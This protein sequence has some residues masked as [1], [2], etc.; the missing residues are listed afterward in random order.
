MD[1]NSEEFSEDNSSVNY[2]STCLHP[3]FSSSSTA[4]LQGI[5][6]KPSRKWMERG[7]QPMWKTCPEDMRKSMQNLNAPLDIAIKRR[8]SKHDLDEDSMVV[9]L[10]SVDSLAMNEMRDCEINPSAVYDS[11][12]SEQPF[13]TPLCL[14]N[15]NK[16]Y[17]PAFSNSSNMSL[18]SSGDREENRYFMRS[19]STS[20]SQSFSIRQYAALSDAT[21]ASTWL[22][23]ATEEANIRS[24][25]QAA[26]PGGDVVNN[27]LI[28]D[29][30]E[31]DR[32][33]ATS[34]LVEVKLFCQHIFQ[35]FNFSFASIGCFCR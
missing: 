6:S 35:Q 33:V 31:S 18:L 28:L 16:K 34:L 25:Q 10:S 1:L 13:R 29:G 2:I 4:P 8:D 32:S 11:K 7:G 5:L 12:I 26:I 30:Y 27:N 3:D 21:L 20:P 19:S 24:K 9:E 23:K 22:Q 15:R 17:T 14:G